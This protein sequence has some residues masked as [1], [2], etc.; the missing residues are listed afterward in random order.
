[1]I[2]DKD[3]NVDMVGTFKYLD[4]GKCRSQILV[5]KFG[6]SGTGI[7]EFALQCGADKFHY[8][9]VSGASVNGVALGANQKKVVSGF[10]VHDTGKNNVVVVDVLD[11]VTFAIHH[12][13]GMFLN[14]QSHVNVTLMN[15]ETGLSQDPQN[16]EKYQVSREESMFSTYQPFEVLSVDES[17]FTNEQKEEAKQLCALVLAPHEHAACVRDK[18]I[19]GISTHM[20]YQGHAKEALEVHHANKILKKAYEEKYGT[21]N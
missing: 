4:V 16:A 14:I 21:T 2:G 20:A 19:S 12:V 7:R 13:E 3:V 8:D 11:E 9:K 17:Q 5:E 15:S 1:M 18:L 10:E 6:T